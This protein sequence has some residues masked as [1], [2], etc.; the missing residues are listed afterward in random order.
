[1]EDNMIISEQ[2]LEN[3]FL[4]F[5]LDNQLM[6]IPLVNVEQIVGVLPTTPLPEMP[7]YC[8]GVV[9]LRGSIVPVIDLRLRFGRV[10]IPY[11]D[12]TSFII[13][14]V[15]QHLVGCVVDYVEE[16]VTVDDKQKSAVPTVGAAQNGDYA[17]GIARL[18]TDESA[19]IV[20]LLDA[21]KI[22]KD[23]DAETIL[24]CGEEE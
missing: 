24:G 9:D 10:E 17:T 6:A 5:M 20:L 1:M 14:R 3:K 2:G 7:D 15:D 13:C 11:T 12:K 23:A 22:V 4:T 18:G 19:K 16:V 8:K 21:A